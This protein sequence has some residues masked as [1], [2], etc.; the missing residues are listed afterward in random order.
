MLEG[1]QSKLDSLNCGG[2]R[3]TYVFFFRID[4]SGFYRHAVACTRNFL[5]SF[6][7]L[8]VL[9]KRA[10]DERERLLEQLRC[11][12]TVGYCFVLYTR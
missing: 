6:V 7:G 10:H 2:H 12:Y 3:K 9:Q 11:V 5:I 8:P 1:F 4:F